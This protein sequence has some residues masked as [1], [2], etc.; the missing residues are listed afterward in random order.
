MIF[1]I[2][3]LAWGLVVY[4]L[5]VKGVACLLGLALGMPELIVWP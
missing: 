4:A 2:A 1:K 3:K 5:A